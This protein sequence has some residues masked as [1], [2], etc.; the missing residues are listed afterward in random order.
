MMETTGCYE[1]DMIM[2]QIE[3]ED[4]LYDCEDDVMD[5]GCYSQRWKAEYKHNRDD[6]AWL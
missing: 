5:R 6:S 2:A 1:L 3:I 4:S